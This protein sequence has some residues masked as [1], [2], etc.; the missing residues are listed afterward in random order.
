M[1][2]I[3][4]QEIINRIFEAIEILIEKKSIPGIIYF[5]EKHK[6]PKSKL[7]AMK[8]QADDADQQSSD[9]KVYKGVP[10]DAVYILAKE[11]G[12]SLEWL[13]FGIGN[14]RKKYKLNA[15]I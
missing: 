11:Y 6:L 12:F 7:Y 9:A 15:E 14:Q 10:F 2:E 3:P 1:S 13:I 4:S 5:I 8:N